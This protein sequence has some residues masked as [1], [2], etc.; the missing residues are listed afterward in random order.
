[1]ECFVQITVPRGAKM[2]PKVNANKIIVNN[3]VTKNMI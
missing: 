1:M 2:V 3:S